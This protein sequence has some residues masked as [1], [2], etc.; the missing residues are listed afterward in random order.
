MNRCFSCFREY[1]DEFDICPFCGEPKSTEPAEAIHLAPGTILQ[2]RYLLGLGIGSGGF[3]IIYK[4]WD[5]KLETVVAVKEFFA[6]RLMTRVAGTNEVIVNK[7]SQAEFSYRQERFLAEA[8]NMA[9]FGAHRSIP[10][11]FE[12]F[13]ENGTAYIVMELLTG[14]PL[15]EYLRQTGGPIDLDFALLITNEI[16]NALKSLHAQGIIHR[17]VAPDNIYICS[18]KELRIK[19]LDLGA[20]KLTD[21]TDKVIDITLK[22]GYSPVE[23]YDNTKS[24]GPWTDIYALGATLYIMLTGI[25]PDEATNRKIDDTVVPPHELNEAIPENLSNAV[26]KALAI[27]RH[28]RFK[29]VDEFLQAV[30]G[31]RKVVSLETER[32]LRKRRRFGGIAAACVA[33]LLIGG[34]V[35]HIFLNKRSEELLQDA[36]I[37]VWFSLASLPDFD[38]ENAIRDI[39]DDFH[40]KFPNVTVDVRAIPENEYASELQSAAQK[41]ELPTLFESTGLPKSV[42]SGAEDLSDILKSEQAAHCLFLNQYTNYYEDKKQLPLAIEIPMAY[43]IIGGP[44][45]IDYNDSLFASTDDFGDA[46]IAADSRY[47]ELLGR[48]FNTAGLLPQENFLNGESNTASVLLSS[49]LALNDVRKLSGYQKMYVF[50][51]SNQIQCRFTYE[52][53][54]GNGGENEIAAGKRLLSWMLGNSYQNTL[55][56]TSGYSNGLDSNIPVYIPINE[57]CFR[58]KAET[59]TDYKPM[60]EI[61]RHFV[62]RQ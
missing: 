53:S 16:G 44:V 41:N 37:S 36:S 7:K 50:Y 34:V 4:A 5:M 56:I 32:K 6:G 45:H 35:F 31:E 27:E 61:Y 20:A 28:M 48:N 60:L 15:N 26:M 62:F 19:L 51:N 49:S 9:K 57:T 58:K 43:L 46:P 52:W 11:V 30:N 54:I 2:G 1:S 23:Q 42:L 22:P 8:R 55:M 47:Q 40:E 59:L 39:T 18:D 10:N 21:N 25:K 12:F 14:L 13:K 17:D 29:T 24:I 3:G 33:L 38:E